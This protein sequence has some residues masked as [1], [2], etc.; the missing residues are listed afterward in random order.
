[1]KQISRSTVID[2]RYDNELEAEAHE[3]VMKDQGWYVIERKN[4]FIK[5]YRS[6]SKSIPEGSFL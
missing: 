3:R 2:Y 4:F 6:Y 5:Q 1:M